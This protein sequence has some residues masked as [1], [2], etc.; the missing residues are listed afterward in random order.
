MGQG[1]RADLMPI[2][3]SADEIRYFNALQG[4]Q[5]VDP[6]TGLREYARMS[7]VIRNPEIRKLFIEIT[8]YVMKKGSL[9]KKIAQL[10]HKIDIPP[11]EPI[12]SDAN[13]KLHKVES[14]G[15]GA[16]K[17]VVLMPSDVV[18]FMDILQGGENL[19]LKMH[20]QQFGLFDEIIRGVGTVAGAIFGG[21]VG[22]GV[23]NAVASKVTGKS[24]RDSAISG[25]KNYGLAT[26]VQ[27]LGNMAGL[28]SVPGTNGF[29]MGA[30]HLASAYGLGTNA[31]LASHAAGLPGAAASSGVGSIS[32]AAAAN[33]AA[34]GMGHML[35]GASK[36]ALPAAMLGAGFLE[37]KKGSEEEEAG[38]RRNR[39]E[40]EEQERRRRARRTMMDEPL[41]HQLGDEY[42]S[43]YVDGRKDGG[44]LRRK[45]FAT[46]GLIGKPVKGKGNGQSD[47]INVDSTK[48]G[49]WIWDASTVADLGDGSTD[50]GW[51]EIQR[52]EKSI[53][54]QPGFK[55]MH[56]LAADRKP[57]KV[58]T[59][60][61]NGEY[62][63]PTK[64]VTAIG[65]GDNKK[66]SDILRTMTE[67]I[68]RYKISKGDK[69]P[70][71]IGDP[72]HF[73]EKAIH[74]ERK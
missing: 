62:R 48:E 8:D 19:D 39:A 6:E 20:M 54:R 4:G 44:A 68:R 28:G 58:K 24:W 30:P 25:V 1:I 34:S 57:V 71:P 64:I 41:K 51:K 38:E 66:G 59:A 53:T 45:L 43:P 52:L 61:S 70:P 7:E 32:A 42:V 12:P 29:F 50:A 69:L 56:E 26:G 18:A 55:H 13:A 33:P 40:H 67:D 22:A 3:V 10:S 65:N 60:L 31:Q 27:S 23:G 46:G 15:E 5:S 16:D 63:T 2:R 14:Y 35:S 49:E 72:M 74:E 37:S 17:K 21:P 47:D 73:L 9:P 36:Y 11:V